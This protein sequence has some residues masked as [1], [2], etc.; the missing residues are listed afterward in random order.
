MND[1]SLKSNI[2]SLENIAKLVLII[3][4]L[5]AVLIVI[6]AFLEAEWIL[7]GYGL[8]IFPYG[9]LMYYFFLVFCGIAKNIFIMKNTAT[10]L[11]NKEYNTKNGQEL[12]SGVKAAREYL[13]R[14][15][16]DHQLRMRVQKCINTDE[17]FRLAQSEGY[18]FNEDELNE[19]KEWLKTFE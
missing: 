6:V 1:T 8:V 9:L 18:S 17:Y 12:L 10:G 4:I 19:A 5:I 15:K 3:F 13:S 7:L 2:K 11:D 14:V 16:K